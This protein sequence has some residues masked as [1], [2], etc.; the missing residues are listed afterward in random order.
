MMGILPGG[1]PNDPEYNQKKYA[2]ET[3]L[4]RDNVGNFFSGQEVVIPTQILV[5]TSNSMEKLEATPNEKLALLNQYKAI[6]KNYGLNNKLNIYGDYESM[7]AC[8]SL[9]NQKNKTRIK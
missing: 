3:L 2:V 6:I 7:L 5:T 1:N 4:A 8:A 9:E